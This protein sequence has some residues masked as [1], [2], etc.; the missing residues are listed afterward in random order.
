MVVPLGF[1]P[2]LTGPV[3]AA[4]PAN[5]MWL[6]V[7]ADGAQCTASAAAVDT[8]GYEGRTFANDLCLGEDVI[9]SGAVDGW[10]GPL[11]SSAPIVDGGADVDLINR[12]LDEYGS[13]DAQNAGLSGWSLAS[14]W[15]ARDVLAAAGGAE[16]SRESVA[17]ALGSYSSTDVPG[18]DSVTCP[19]PSY[20]SGACNMAPIMVTVE[21]GQLTSPDGFVQLDFSELDFLLE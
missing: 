21:N 8:V 12:V 17:E 11:V 3:S 2:D 13:G 15:V 19:G 9:A 4:D 18:L 7:L 10:S 5:D 1:E 14:T 16:A 20:W 6:F